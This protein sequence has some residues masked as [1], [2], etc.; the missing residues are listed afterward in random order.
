MPT[1]K[2]KKNMIRLYGMI[3]SMILKYH[4]FCQDGQSGFILN[5]CHLNVKTK[6]GLIF[7]KK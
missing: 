1:V 7:Y 2:K 4:A 6:F 3:I 5:D